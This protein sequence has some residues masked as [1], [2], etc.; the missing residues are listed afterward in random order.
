MQSYKDIL[1]LGNS[2]IYLDLYLQHSMNRSELEHIKNKIAILAS[3]N[4]KELAKLDNKIDKEIATL[5]A[6]YER[7]RNDIMKYAAGMY[8]VSLWE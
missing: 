6:T 2:C 3:E 7:Y 1:H 5:L 8:S 4:E